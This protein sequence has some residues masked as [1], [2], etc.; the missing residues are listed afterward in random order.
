MISIRENCIDGVGWF[1]IELDGEPIAHTAGFDVSDS[2]QR[3]RWRSIANL[4]GPR[5]NEAREVHT[6]CECGEVFNRAY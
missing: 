2:S 6:C 1:T 4:L 5:E 3:E